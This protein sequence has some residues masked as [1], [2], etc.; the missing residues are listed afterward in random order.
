MA[1]LLAGPARDVV[2]R[3]LGSDVMNFQPINLNRT[4]MGCA[5]ITATARH[6]RRHPTA[7]RSSMPH[8]CG[9]RCVGPDRQRVALHLFELPILG[10][11]DFFIIA[12][13]AD[14]RRIKVA[15]G[16][17]LVDDFSVFE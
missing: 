7:P 12:I 15:A 16:A 13:Y 4:R 2:Q 3:R 8:A 17:H 1:D 11:L 6:G 14:V 10:K 9:L 5:Q